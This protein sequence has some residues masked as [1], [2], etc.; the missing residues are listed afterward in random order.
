M[1]R[2]LK[3]LGSIS[4]LSTKYYQFLSSQCMVDSTQHQ[5]LNKRPEL[6]QMA[7]LISRGMFSDLWRLPGWVQVSRRQPKGSHMIHGL[8]PIVSEET[9]EPSTPNQQPPARRQ[10]TDHFPAGSLLFPSNSSDRLLLLIK[11]RTHTEHTLS[12]G[13]CRGW[14]TCA[15][16]PLS[17]S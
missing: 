1:P 2:K 10:L 6:L 5:A 13:G 11:E 12:G 16:L 7:H 3:A 14:H 17:S 9:G 4:R 8:Y 15:S